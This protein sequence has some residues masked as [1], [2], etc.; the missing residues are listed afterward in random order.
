M[1]TAADVGDH[2]AAQVL[3]TQVT[4]AHH[5]LALVWADGGYTDSLVEYCLT[6]LALVLAITATTCAAS[7]CCPSGWIVERFF[8]HLMRSRR[9]ARDFERSI[10]SAEAMVYWSM[11]M[12]MTRRVARPRPSRA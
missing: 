1:V 3:L 5:L 12:L 8:A 10:A 4:A 7:A 11:T 9:L 2:A 6:A